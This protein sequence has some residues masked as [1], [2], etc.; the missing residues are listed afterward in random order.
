MK[1]VIR[2]HF[3]PIEAEEDGI[4]VFGLADIKDDAYLAQ[5]EDAVAS[6]VD[7]DEVW[8][9]PDLVLDVLQSFDPEATLIEIPT[10][11]V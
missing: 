10:I 4:D 1:H 5:I 3:I 9:F 2:F 8:N 11:Y 7:A 6:Y